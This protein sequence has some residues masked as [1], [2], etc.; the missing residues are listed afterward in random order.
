VQR[1][2]DA[3]EIPFLLAT[4]CSAVRIPGEF[5]EPTVHLV[6]IPGR[7]SVEGYLLRLGKDRYEV[8]FTFLGEDGKPLPVEGSPT[9]LATRIDGEPPDAMPATPDGAGPQELRT[10]FLSRGH[11]FSFGR[12]EPGTWRFDGAASGEGTSVAGCFQQTLGD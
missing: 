7:G 8:H 6:E 11:Y 1:G 12:L 10:L 2:A 3:V 5:P 9:I 4:E